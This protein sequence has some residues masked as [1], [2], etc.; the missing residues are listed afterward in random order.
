MP[1]AACE[2]MESHRCLKWAVVACHGP[3][4][5]GG[6]AVR[7]AACDPT[8]SGQGAHTSSAGPP[9][10]CCSKR[11]TGWL[12]LLQQGEVAALDLEKLVST[13]AAQKL[14]LETPAGRVSCPPSRVPAQAVS[15]C[16]ECSKGLAAF[17]WSWLLLPGVDSI[18]SL[19]GT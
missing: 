11:D 16:P 5:A 12:F 6:C 15:P 9:L 19:A 18:L 1:G 4:G 10:P 8:G 14:I 2:L 13:V 7:G 3:G 17:G